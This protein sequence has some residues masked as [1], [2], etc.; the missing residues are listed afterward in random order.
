MTSSYARLSLLGLSLVSV[1]RSSPLSTSTHNSSPRAQWSIAPL[2]AN[3]HPHGTVNN[4]YIVMFKDDV[5]PELMD[6]H[7][8]FLQAAHYADPLLADQSGI[9]HVYNG[10]IS[11]YAGFFSDAVVDQL[12]SL[13]EVE[14]IERDQIVHT[15]DVQKTA[16]WVSSIPA[17]RCAIRATPY[18]ADCPICTGSG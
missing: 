16:P 18:V 7:F 1:V 17:I 9:R 13:P 10:H 8:N 2:V 4:S 3:E 6:N 12:R 11:G 5:K 15:T 14:Y